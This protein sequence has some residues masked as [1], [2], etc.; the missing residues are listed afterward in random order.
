MLWKG[1]NEAILIDVELKNRHWEPA[2][3][4]SVH[5]LVGRPFGPSPYRGKGESQYLERVG[6]AVVVLTTIGLVL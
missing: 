2:C 6:A 3:A 4:G 5:T 1:V